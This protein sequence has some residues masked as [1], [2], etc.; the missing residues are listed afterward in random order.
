MM[1]ES[2]KC[3]KSE[4]GPGGKSPWNSSMGS[5]GAAPIFT[6]IARIIGTAK[7]ETAK[8]VSGDLH[9]WK[10]VRG[11]EKSAAGHLWE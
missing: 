11:D 3:E 4:T 8:P 10:E 7:W 6:I 1:A 5:C 2:D 9:R